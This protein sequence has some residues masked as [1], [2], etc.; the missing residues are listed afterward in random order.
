MFRYSVFFL[1]CLAFTSLNALKRNIHNR[2]IDDDDDLSIKHSGKIRSH[3]DHEHRFD[4]HHF[5]HDSDDD[6]RVNDDHDDDDFGKLISPTVL[7][8]YRNQF[9]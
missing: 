2:D 7:L 4:E 1:I 6:F 5:D 8:I 3:F 9:I